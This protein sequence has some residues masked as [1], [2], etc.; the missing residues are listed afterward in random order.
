MENTRPTEVV[1]IG[2]E[3]GGTAKTATTLCIANALTALGFKVLVIDLDPSGNF[4]DAALPEFPQYVLY[5]V[6]NGKCPLA[7]AIVHTEICDVLPTVKD[8]APEN[9]S[10]FLAAGMPERK[11]LGD[12]FTSWVGRRGAEKCIYNLLHHEAYAP[13]LRQ[14]DFILMDSQ[15]SDSLIITNAI[16]AAN[17]IIFPCEPVSGAQDGLIKFQKSIRLTR[18]SYGT[19]AF[20]DGL[21][22]TKYDEKWGTRRQM[23]EE[24]QT[25]AEANGIPV[26]RT[27]FRSSAS[28]ETSMNECLPIL[29]PKYL[30]MGWGAFDALN[31]TLEFLAKRGMAPRVNY[32]GV[33]RDEA[34]RLIYRRKGDTYWMVTDRQENAVQLEVKRFE[35]NDLTNADRIQANAEAVGTTI[36]YS[37]ESIE[38]MF[39]A[40]RGQGQVVTCLGQN[41]KHLSDL[42]KESQPESGENSEAAAC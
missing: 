6:L 21:V 9:D 26:Y 23:V 25:M 29:T 42:F 28:I 40:A 7:N 32:P 11:S 4:S 2:N 36:F 38:S 37:P 34:G 15:P 35:E 14:Y 39:R 12:L 27:R 1:L 33:L 24:I 20:I 18:E 5:D 8:I 41:P 10:P 19:N 31:F 17:S 3:K 16:V 22:F 30:Y 13:F